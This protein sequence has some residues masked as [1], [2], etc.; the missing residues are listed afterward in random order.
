MVLEVVG[1][2]E[3]FCLDYFNNNDVSLSLSNSINGM[4]SYLIYFG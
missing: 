1:V 4:F 3:C 2:S